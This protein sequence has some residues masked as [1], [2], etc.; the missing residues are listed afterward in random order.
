VAVRIGIIGAGNIV[1]TRHLPAFA[2][3]ADVQVVAV[4][5][6]RREAAQAAGC[7]RPR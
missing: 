1:K 7:K 5:N 6:R 3:E 2:E 4:C